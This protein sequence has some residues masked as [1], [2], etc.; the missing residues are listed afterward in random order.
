MDR[1]GSVAEPWVT[2]LDV[3]GTPQFAKAREAAS[4]LIECM[5]DPLPRG[6]LHVA[7]TTNK[8]AMT[9]IMLT[10]TRMLHVMAHG[11]EGRL[12]PDH[13]TKLAEWFS[14]RFRV[15]VLTAYC[16][17]YDVWPDIDVLML[18]ACDTFTNGWIRDLTHLI[19]QGRSVL[20]LGTTES[21]TWPRATAYTNAFYTA[22]L[23]F[24]LDGSGEEFVCAAREAHGAA[25][26][27]FRILCDDEPPFRF[28]TIHGRGR[29]SS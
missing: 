13:R 20:F 7:A 25:T 21:V 1:A 22:L 16:R 27:A 8:Q 12:Q 2:L 15:D 5:G 9:D 14:R 26:R 28:R 6:A 10:R 23:G 24:E 18:D 4:W 19:P 3:G 17:M 29:A 11:T